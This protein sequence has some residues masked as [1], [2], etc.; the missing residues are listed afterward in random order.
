MR[1]RRDAGRDRQQGLSSGTS[2]RIQPFD[3]PSVEPPTR[4]PF[5]PFHAVSR[6]VWSNLGPRHSRAPPQGREGCPGAT[7]EHPGG[8]G[9][10]G[11]SRSTVYALCAE[12]KFMRV[13]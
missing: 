4:R 6:G 12:G 1:V 8:R 10:V 2:H 13:V 9:T 11:V 3:I 7:S 5:T